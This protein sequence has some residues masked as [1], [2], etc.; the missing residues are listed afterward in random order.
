MENEMENDLMDEIGSMPNT[1]PAET[2]TEKSTAVDNV[3]NLRLYDDI[4]ESLITDI[5]SMEEKLD[6]L[7]KIATND[8][9]TKGVIDDFKERLGTSCQ[10]LVELKTYHTSGATLEHKI[11]QKEIKLAKEELGRFANLATN[12]TQT[13]QNVEKVCEQ[14]YTV[15]QKFKQVCEQ[16]ENKTST[17]ESSL[18]ATENK[19]NDVAS[20]YTQNLQDLLGGQLRELEASVASSKAN[21]EEIAKISKNSIAKTFK[22]MSLASFGAILIS[23]V[24]FVFMLLR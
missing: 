17:L 22:L 4:V 18:K 1:I 8:N 5:T 19:L 9:E 3:K 21:L 12:V 2:A 16:I 15:E 6:K 24:V 13:K 11:L 14:I 7:N 10:T 23:G 20:K